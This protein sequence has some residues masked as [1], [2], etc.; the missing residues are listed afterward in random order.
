M[1]RTFVW[2]ALVA[3]VS[4]LLVC[5]ADQSFVRRADAVEIKL[6]PST[7]KKDDEPKT[8][9][10]TSEKS[11]EKNAAPKAEAGGAAKPTSEKTAPLSV[12]TPKDAAAASDSAKEK[13]HASKSASEAARNAKSEKTSSSS[14]AK[15][16]DKTEPEKK[17][18]SVSDKSSDKSAAEKNAVGSAAA[19]KS[20]AEN[21]SE[22]SGKTDKSASDK[23]VGETPRASASAKPVKP[24]TEKE[25]ERRYPRNQNATVM[26]L[27]YLIPTK[28]LHNVRVLRAFTRVPRVE[29]APKKLRDSAYDNTE[30]PLE[31][32]MRLPSPF[33][34]AYAI[35]ALDPQETDRTLV[36]ETGSGY[37]AAILSY[38][39]SEVY[40]IGADRAAVKRASDACK[41]LGYA[42]VRHM[43]GDPA[44]GWSDAAPFNKILLTRAV[45]E[46]PSVLL[47][48]LADG[49]VLVAP[50]GDAYRQFFVVATKKDGVLTETTLLPTRVEA[51]TKTA[52]ERE[53]PAPGLANGGFEELDPEPGTIGPVE[54]TFD[55]SA[56]AGADDPAASPAP[57]PQVPEG[58][59]AIPKRKTTPSGWYDAWNFEIASHGDA[60]DGRFA[61]LFRNDTIA[62]DH[63]KKDRNEE[64]I[65]AA[66]LPEERAEKTEA[67]EAIKA[68][69]RDCELRSQ[70]RQSFPVDGS[71]VKK[72]VFA[73]SYRA[74]VLASRYDFNVVR[75]A[76]IEFSDKDGKSVGSVDL[77]T[78][79]PSP[80][81]WKAFSVDV[82]VP[83]RAKE[84]TLTIGLLDGVGAVE[85]DALDIHDKFEKA[86]R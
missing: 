61:C 62:A 83:A 2:R 71:A 51:L 50:V 56:N 81:P 16:T 10:K 85:M 45:P 19:A 5:S 68:A 39:T 32:S 44:Q 86:K 13:T 49:G 55:A 57:V 12:E 64:R 80:T 33:N 20:A 58:F 24:L 75:L 15:A 23:S 76:V 31:S 47:E 59:V 27:E 35:E 7:K 22:S 73:G 6:R 69:Q 54:A 1:K 42:N 17:A 8:N 63:Q 79:S 53:L 18:S 36:V 28:A 21:L 11:V 30:L 77:L 84:A 26:T 65:R 52:L 46:I 25:R 72:L 67:G 4:L 74:Q 48:Q 70:M 41:K 38:L 29:F 34:A 3:A 40:A 37:H 66:T 43:Q 60:A 78:V 82:D 14:S 9:V